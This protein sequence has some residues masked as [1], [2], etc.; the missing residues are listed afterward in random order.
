MAQEDYTKERMADFAMNIE[1]F[2]IGQTVEDKDGSNC[3]IINKTLNSIDVF[4]GKKT[5]KGIDHT[6]WF[7]MNRFNER[8]KPLKT[9]Q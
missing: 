9:E 2:S 7:D 8:F 4:I 5:P 1:E 6:Q 3:K